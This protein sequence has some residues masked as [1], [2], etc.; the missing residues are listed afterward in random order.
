MDS[1]QFEGPKKNYGETLNE[2]L[3]IHCIHP[4]KIVN[5]LSLHFILFFI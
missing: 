1:I 3:L 4:V 2:W 5:L